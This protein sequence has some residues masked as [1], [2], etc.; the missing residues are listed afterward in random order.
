MLEEHADFIDGRA[1]AALLPTV[2]ERLQ[3]RELYEMLL[4]FNLV[5]LFLQTQGLSGLSLDN[6]TEEQAVPAAAEDA[7]QLDLVIQNRA[8]HRQL[9]RVLPWY[10]RYSGH[11]RRL[12][13]PVLRRQVALQRPPQVHAPRC[14][15]DAGL[16]EGQPP[17]VGHR[18]D[19][20]SRAACRCHAARREL[21]LP[22]TDA[23]HHYERTKQ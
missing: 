6:I 11:L 7:D 19:R 2:V 14:P 20:W 10:V 21:R 18:H 13:A 5:T 15:R 1:L 9:H 22:V 8:R 16:P 4:H 17:P 23:L 3:L 12:Q